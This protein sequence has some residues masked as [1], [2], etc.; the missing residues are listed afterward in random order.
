MNAIC[1][2]PDGNFRNRFCGIKTFPHLAADL[3]VQFTDGIRGT[4]SLQSEDCHAKRLRFVGGVA[5]AQRHELL[6]R[7]FDLRAKAVESEMHQVGTESI[8]SGF[9]WRVRREVAL[10][11][12]SGECRV[13]LHP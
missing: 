10:L 6:V 7:A 9:Y 12:G 13:K 11:A 3:A 8:V 1:D 5:A 4:R 2:V